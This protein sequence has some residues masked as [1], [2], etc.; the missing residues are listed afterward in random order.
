MIRSNYVFQDSDKNREI[1]KDTLGTE[2][3]DNID[4]EAKLETVLKP[5]KD[6]H[7]NR[8]LEQPE[9]DDSSNEGVSSRWPPIDWSL[10]T[11]M[12]FIAHETFDWCSGLT[13]MDEAVGLAGFAQCEK[14][15]IT[16][17]GQVQENQFK[18]LLPLV[19][20]VAGR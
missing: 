10:C 14:P 9:G 12:R 3:V 8:R 2:K 17:H 11:R 13:S 15:L 6:E 18:R 16:S 5:P 4:I 20:V 1:S 19:T 7:I